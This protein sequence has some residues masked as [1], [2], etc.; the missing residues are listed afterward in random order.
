MIMA[1]VFKI[2]FLVV[3]T[4]VVIVS[5]WLAATALFPAAVARALELYERRSLRITLLGALLGVPLFLLGAV[6]TGAGPTPFLKIG[7]GSLASLVLLFALFGSAGLCQRIGNG[8]PAPLDEF[9]PWRRVYRG[10]TVLALTFV[11]PVVGWFVI[12][13]WTLISGFGA[14]ISVLWSM[15]RKSQRLTPT[16]QTLLPA[17]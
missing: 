1:D 10:G 16:A 17:I 8:L 3:G 12:F 13:F 2:V 14:T 5:Y 6:L 4:L 15:R 7:G 9:Q 11:L